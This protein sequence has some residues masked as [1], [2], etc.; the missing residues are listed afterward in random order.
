MTTC[1]NF[2][3]TGRPK[4]SFSVQVALSAAND[5]FE[6]CAGR[7]RKLYAIEKLSGKLGTTVLIAWRDLNEE[8]AQS[9]RASAKALTD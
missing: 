2:F 9:N 3:H 4:Q 1:D 5:A 7:L 6:T 8:K